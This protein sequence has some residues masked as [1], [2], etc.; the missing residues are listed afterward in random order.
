MQLDLL[1]ARL[2]DERVEVSS[3]CVAAAVPPATALRRIKT[4][5]EHGL[6]VRSADPQHG[7]RVFIELT[8]KAAAR[9]EPYLDAVPR[10]S[11]LL[12]SGGACLFFLSDLAA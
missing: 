9:L 7:R 3:L 8:D 5:C 10:L 6:F 12:V 11:Q 1:A 4:L 2:A